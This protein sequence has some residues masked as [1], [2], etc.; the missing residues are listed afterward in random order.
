[1]VTEVKVFAKY[2]LEVGV[3]QFMTY[4]FVPEALVLI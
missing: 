1:M 2:A 3:T 4:P